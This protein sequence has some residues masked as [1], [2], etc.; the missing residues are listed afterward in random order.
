VIH[1]S[2]VHCECDILVMKYAQAFY[3]ADQEVAHQLA[4]EPVRFDHTAVVLLPGEYSFVDSCGLLEAKTVLFLGAPA[5]QHFGQAQ[6][7]DFAADALRIVATK[8]RD[9]VTVAMTLHGIS[10]SPHEEQPMIAQI[11]GLNLAL[12]FP[13]VRKKVKRVIVAERLKERVN[14]F[15][16]LL[17]QH[18]Q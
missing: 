4:K 12:N 15:E 9:P 6:I 2:V 13:G 5:L 3:G 14:R 10:Y 16:A 11:E 18:Q 8:A 1:R 17:R 7:R